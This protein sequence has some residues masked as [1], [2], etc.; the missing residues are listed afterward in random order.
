M[1]IKIS[2]NYY[3]NT[4]IDNYDQKKT[5]KKNDQNKD[6]KN[7][8]KKKDDQNKDDKNKDDKKKDDT[9]KDNLSLKTNKNLSGTC[10][11]I[12]FKYN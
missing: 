2:R 8:D 5:S 7:G 10:S 9:N 3:V 11:F 4:P 6:D 12:A 1:H